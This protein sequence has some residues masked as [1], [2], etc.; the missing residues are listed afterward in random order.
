MQ[1]CRPIPFMADEKP[2]LGQIRRELLSLLASKLGR[3]LTGTPVMVP[4]DA[5]AVGA[6]VETT[7]LS[8]SGQPSNVE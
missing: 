1:V 6:E 7:R 2:R 8:P 4:V 5:A 3:V